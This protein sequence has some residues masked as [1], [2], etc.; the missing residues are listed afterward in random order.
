MTEPTDP[1]VEPE[2]LSEFLEETQDED[3][4]AEELSEET[5]REDAAEQR[6]E[7]LRLRDSPLTERGVEIDPADAAEQARVVDPGDEEYR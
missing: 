3:A 7:L 2:S 4:F 6:L 5:P 1:R